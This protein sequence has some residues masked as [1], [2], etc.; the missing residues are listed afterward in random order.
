MTQALR[1]RATDKHGVVH[2]VI[3][4]LWFLMETRCGVR[5]WWRDRIASPFSDNV[6]TWDGFDPT[7]NTT[8][9]ACL[10]KETRR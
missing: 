8:C 2:E 5:S 4:T 1:V 7:P 10:V 6:M 3:E 9:M